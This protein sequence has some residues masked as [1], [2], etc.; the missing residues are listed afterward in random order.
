MLARATRVEVDRRR[1]LG[2]CHDRDVRR[3]ATMSRT[4]REV[5]TSPPR[6]DSSAVQVIRM[7]ELDRDVLRNAMVSECRCACC[8]V[9]C[10]K[11]RGRS[12]G[13]N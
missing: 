4:R 13:V 5:P 7:S 2:T 12:R 8:P 1:M 3:N 6:R 11:E 9:R 10:A